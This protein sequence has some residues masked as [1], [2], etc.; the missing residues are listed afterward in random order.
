MGQIFLQRV[1]AGI[2][3]NGIELLLQGGLFLRG[4]TGLGFH[5][6]YPPG[7]LVGGFHGVIG[8]Y[9]LL[10][11]QRPVNVLG[12][13]QSLFCRVDGLG[14]SGL[15]AVHRFLG[16]L[17]GVP[18]DVG[19]VLSLFGGVPDGLL[20]AVGSD[21]P[22]QV[23]R[24]LDGLGGLLGQGFG[25]FVRVVGLDD[26]VQ[27][28]LSLLVSTVDF[29]VYS[30][31]DR[32]GIGE[33][34]VRINLLGLFLDGLIGGVHNGFGLEALVI[35]LVYT[36]HRV[37][38]AGEILGDLLNLFLGVLGVAQGLHSVL[39]GLRGVLRGLFDSLKGLLGGGG[40]RIPVRGQ[41]GGGEE[42]QGQTGGCQPG[43]NA[44]FCHHFI[45]LQINFG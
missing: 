28:L 30:V 35:G 27:R 8:G 40:L 4:H 9:A 16:L 3:Q 17:G 29:S 34:D 11:I 2:R 12:G 24:G 39:L 1:G 15:R 31:G 26:S 42:A 23:F 41:G 38:V 36:V 5:L 45:L 21:A 43:Q 13:F 14:V 37:V 7:D 22:G 33:V 10:V 19:G 32:V 6:L 44:F 20:P 25:R 18:G